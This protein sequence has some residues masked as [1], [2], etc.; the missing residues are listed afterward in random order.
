[1]KRKPAGEQRLV[2]SPL[3]PNWGD[4][5]DLRLY[6]ACIHPNQYELR[7]EGDRILGMQLLAAVAAYAVSHL[8][9]YRAA[10]R[11]PAR[12]DVIKTVAQAIQTLRQL[13]EPAYSEWYQN[14]QPTCGGLSPFAWFQEQQQPELAQL[15]RFKRRVEEHDIFCEIPFT[16]EVET[17][18]QAAACSSNVRL[19]SA[20]K[21]AY[22]AKHTK[23]FLTIIQSS[24]VAPDWEDEFALTPYFASWAP[25]NYELGTPSNFHFAQEIFESAIGE[26]GGWVTLYRTAL[27]GA[28]QLDGVMEAVVRCTMKIVELGRGLYMEWFHRPQ[29]E[30]RGSSPQQW[31]QTKGLGELE[32]LLGGS[33]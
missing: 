23:P 3:V 8:G 32:R 27:Q 29:P 10:V 21:S 2:H 7:S 18:G 6:F 14:P 9:V 11:A 5:F 22:G 26:F 15:L 28:I 16:E 31:F 13:G 12:S 33:A 30:F 17:S 24:C 19:D 1:M 4:E 25:V 20:K